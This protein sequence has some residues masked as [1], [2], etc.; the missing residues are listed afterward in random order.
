MKNRNIRKFLLLFFLMFTIGCSEKLP[1]NFPKK[2]AN[3][4]V[5]L[6]YENKPVEGAS[7]SFISDDTSVGYLATA[8]TADDGVAQLETSV[9]QFSKPGIPAGA[10]KVIVTHI[11]KTSIELTQQ[12]VMTLSN[13]ELKKRE[14]D[15]NK[16]RAKLP[17]PV[18]KNWSDL[19]STPLKITIPEKGGS[20][21]IEITDSKTFEQ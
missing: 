12:E 11:P 20:V 8:F 5:K 6:M 13:D 7:V 9:N 14:D 18:P 4:T 3:F 1:D 10:Y 17:H 19:K 2:L 16:E 21:M 15:V